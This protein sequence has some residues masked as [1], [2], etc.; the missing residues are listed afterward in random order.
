[1]DAACWEYLH[2]LLQRDRLPN[3][4]ELAARGSAGVLRSVMPPITPA[5]WSSLVTGANPG[6]HG[7]YDWVRRLPGGYEYAPVNARQRVGT[8]VWKRLNAA[9]IRTGV[10]NIPLT[11]PVEG[12]DGFMLCGFGTPAAKRDLTYPPEAL[13]EIESRF[14]PYQPDIC[15]N[16]GGHATVWDYQVEREFQSRQVRIAAQLSR[17]YQVQVL[18]INLMLL[19]HANHLMANMAVVEQ[20][21]VDADADLGLLLKEFVPDNVMLISDHGSRR[22][23]GVFLLQAWLAERGYL[24]RTPRPPSERA[25]AVNYLLR[26]WRN[27]GNGFAARAGRRLLR[28][29][30][31]R[32][33][34]PVIRRLRAEL[35][36][37]IPLATLQMETTD[38]F[39][40]AGTSVYPSGS[41]RGNLNLNMIGREAEGIVPEGERQALLEQL[42]L[43]LSTVVDPETN[44]PLFVG[45]YRPVELYAGPFIENAPDL[46]G[47][48]YASRWSIV[49]NLPGL[50]RRPWRHFLTGERW[51]GD[52]SRDGIY[53]F[54]GKDFSRQTDPGKAGLLDIPATLLYLYSVPQ[55]EDYDGRPLL[56]TMRAEVILKRPIEYQP[57][58]DRQVEITNI[59]ELIEGEDE[60][61]ARLIDLGYL[62]G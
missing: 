31:L 2:P 27:G 36:N 15:M 9:G 61:V 49:N 4:A 25:Q 32:L 59:G 6:K 46:T 54:A 56:E 13:A 35:E 21:M 7:I 24:K 33:P 48:Y 17:A 52:H 37:V 42:C 22:V 14:G 16:Q 19:D 34:R 8:P 10:V 29:G 41:N 40:P 43:E 12:L 38:R 53:V 30:L 39:L 5:A 23:R 57:G 60:L 26:Q 18:F 51:Y 1:M 3:L 20:A 62:Q 28:E 47:D 58:D 45:L 11:Y 50:N 55:P 44:E